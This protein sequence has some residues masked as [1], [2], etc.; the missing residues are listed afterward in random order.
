MG[1]TNNR[2]RRTCSRHDTRLGNRFLFT[3]VAQIR[4]IDYSTDGPQRVVLSVVANEFTL[5][6]P[7]SIEERGAK[8]GMQGC[9]FELVTRVLSS[10][11]GLDCVI[12]LKRYDLSDY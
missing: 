11:S 5:I 2:S 12:L 4:T 9:R 6:H 7:V 3:V 8:D 1:G 10:W